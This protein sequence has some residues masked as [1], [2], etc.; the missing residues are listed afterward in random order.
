MLSV[1]TDAGFDVARKLDQG[2]VELEFP[3]APTEAYRAHVDERDHTAVV[4][5]LQ[6]FFEPE[7]VVV[8]GASPRAGSIGGDLF[9]NIV[10]GGFHGRAYPVNREGKPVAG[11]EGYESIEQIPDPIDLA[12]VCL[13]GEARPRRLRSGAPTRDAGAL[14]HLGGLRR[15]R[16][17]KESRVR[18]SSSHSSAATAPG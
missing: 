10:T 6:S 9:R 8:M 1:F 4:A 18:S 11:V 12:V 7:S 3:L 13:P 14:R 17:A 16:R 5:S 15:D 2:T